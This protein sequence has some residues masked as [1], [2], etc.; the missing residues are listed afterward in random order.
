MRR[1]RRLAVAAS[2]AATFLCLGLI[3]APYSVQAGSLALARWRWARNGGGDY[4]IVVAQF[5]NCTTGHY[6]LTVRRGQV[7]AV[8]ALDQPGP[9]GGLNPA[10]FQ[11]LTVEAA[12]GR[13]MQ[14][15]RI[16]WWPLA[17]WRHPYTVQYDP[18]LGY[19]TRFESGERDA[20]IFFYVYAAQILTLAAS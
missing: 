11:H 2:A 15:V 10:R 20:P 4:T 6:R 16:G 12:F 18:K 19:V 17:R 14:A 9:A 13:A 8:E 1:W 3:L 5:C 7:I